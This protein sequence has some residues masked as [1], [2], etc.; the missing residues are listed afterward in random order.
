MASGQVRLEAP[1][2][3]ASSREKMV[4]GPM[5]AGEGKRVGFSVGIARFGDILNKE[6]PIIEMGPRS[7]FVNPAVGGWQWPEGEGS[8]MTGPAGGPWSERRGAWGVG[9]VAWSER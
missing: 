9:R 6:R 3:T 1:T 8:R 5:A 2:L 7:I 4:C